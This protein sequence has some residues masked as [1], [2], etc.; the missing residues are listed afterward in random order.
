MNIEIPEWV[1]HAVFYQIFPD[2]F[3]RSPRLQHPH[4]IEFKAWGS[5]PA[6][7]GLQGGDLLGIVDRLDYL[8]DL[9]VTA[10][11]LNPIFSAP[12]NHRY[13]T[14]DYYQV[15]PLLGG[16][17]A[18]RELL[19]EAH[20]RGMRVVLDGVFNHCGRGFWAFHHIMENR[21][22]SP[23]LNWFTI[24]GYPLNAYLDD[25][26]S[27]ARYTY[28][29]SAPSLPKFNTDNPG[30]RQYLLQ[31]AAHWLE[32]GI[33]GW[34]LDAPE[35]ILDDDF[36]REFR[37]KVKSI[38]PQAYI[39]GEIWPPAQHWLQ[40]DM[41]D[42]VMNYVITGPILA[43][44]GGG[45]INRAWSNRAIPLDAMDAVEFARKINT[46]LKTY[47]WQIDLAQL[48]MLD[49][50][51]MPRALWLLQEDKQALRQAVL[52]QMCMP[53]APCIYYGDEIGLSAGTDPH[54]RQAFPWQA[55]ESWDHELLTFY[56]QAI[57]L[58]HTYPALRN[59]NFDSIDT[60]GKTI[61]YR[62]SL[63]DQEIL[64]IQNA[65]RKPARLSLPVTNL[66]FQHYQQVWPPDSRQILHANPTIDLE[67]PAQS[68]LVLASLE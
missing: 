13:N 20:R 30:A 19:D 54:C 5:N 58:R 68:S 60:Q 12:A 64:V 22:N 31:V 2:R 15:D 17:A 38:N 23:Y 56:K 46:M 42:A 24:H 21:E 9:G 47:D 51:D 50:H 18:L 33:D 55:P 35:E 57:A 67:L 4:G 65:D 52:C 62:R 25:R 36:W 37:Q 66:H 59:G 7:Q 6:E 3:R 61:A 26:S 63:P 44:F 45:K 14:Y 29:K 8:Q 10:L 39:V 53:G 28:W 27:Q 1:Q 34:R 43:F 48:N 32:F 40:G 41:F 49:S 11:Y 16:N